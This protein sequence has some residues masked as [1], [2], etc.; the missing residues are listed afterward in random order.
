[1]LNEAQQSDVS[2][3]QLLDALPWLSRPAAFDDEP[4]LLEGPG[5]GQ[6]AAQVRPF[7]PVTSTIQARERASLVDGD[8]GDEGPRMR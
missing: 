7:V 5:L 2:L 8:T 4:Q 1:M 6:V 3:A